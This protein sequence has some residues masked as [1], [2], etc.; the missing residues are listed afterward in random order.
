MKDF[1]RRIDPTK[2]QLLG[3]MMDAVD[4]YFP[5]EVTT[6]TLGEFAYQHPVLMADQPFVDAFHGAG[7]KNVTPITY[8][9]DGEGRITHALRGHQQL[10]TLLEAL[11][12]GSTRN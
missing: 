7:W 6:R 8:I 4:D 5:P 3:I 12:Q 9:A 1:Y 10:Q 11:P 2:V